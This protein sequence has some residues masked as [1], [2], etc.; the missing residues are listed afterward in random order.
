LT[1]VLRNSNGS[2]WKLLNN[3]QQMARPLHQSPAFKSTSRAISTL[4]TPLGSASSSSPQKNASSP[5]QF[6]DMQLLTRRF[7]QQHKNEDGGS[8]IRNFASKLIATV[9]AILGIGSGVAYHAMSDRNSIFYDYYKVACAKSQGGGGEDCVEK[10][11]EDSACLRKMDREEEMILKANA[12]LEKALKEIKSKAIEYTEA[13]M[14]AYC[15]AIVLMQEY[16]DQSY[17]AIDA[18]QME[19]PKF[20]EYWCCV[21][22]L[23]KKRCEA[24]KD[25][26]TKG[27]CAWELLCRLRE[28]IESGKA[29]KY[30]SC[31]PLLVT[32]EEC[33]CCAEKELLNLKSKMDCIQSD[34]D[35][36]ELYRQLIDDFKRDL[37]SDID[38][39]IDPETCK[40]TFAE[41]E[42]A[43]MINQAYKRVL[44][45][46]KEMAQVLVCTGN[47]PERM[48]TTLC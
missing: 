41:Q 12:D 22:E 15:E 32:A 37:K 2:C 34:H 28:V 43:V 16:L 45:A 8:T 47:I 25:A 14:K 23:A 1:N 20:E 11:C 42:T 6:R 44:R 39:A 5:P 10:K 17:C 40:L 46:H 38:Q 30:T 29:C 19:S 18:D 9:G 4:K 36:V 21:Y 31:N 48:Q 35:L 24:V 27:Q 3:S 26:L 33:L 7:S 13:A